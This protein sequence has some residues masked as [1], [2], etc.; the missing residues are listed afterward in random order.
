MT[1]YNHNQVKDNCGFGLIANMDGEVSHKIVRT[2]IA[3]LANMQH[4]GGISADGKTGDSKN[5]AHGSK[6]QLT[7]STWCQ[8]LDICWSEIASRFLV[9]FLKHRNK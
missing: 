9:E 7:R 3:G 8:I 2:A 5:R 4:R 1:L 6:N